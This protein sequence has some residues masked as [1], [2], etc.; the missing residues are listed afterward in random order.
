[1]EQLT[2]LE[3]LQVLGSN[4][5]QHPLF[6]V[7]LLIPIIIF[8]S[9]KK[10]GKK[11]F[12]IIYL[13]AI[14]FV[15]F[16]GNNII[17]ELFDNLMDGLFMTLYFPN[18]ITLFIVVVLCSIFALISLFSKKM[19]KINKV[20]NITGFAIV[21]VIFCLILT[22]VKVNQINIYA[23]NALYSNNELLTLMQLLIGTF[24]L[25]VIAI[26]II[27]GINRVTDIL[28]GKNRRKIKYI[29]IN[30][31]KVG[32]INVK[33]NEKPNKP[34]LKPFKFDVNKIESIVVNDSAA[35]ASANIF[36]MTAKPVKKKHKKVILDESKPIELNDRKNSKLKIINVDTN[37]VVRLNA[38][39]LGENKLDKK[40]SI[41]KVI[42]IDY[43]KMAQLNAPLLGEVK[44]DKRRP[45]L[46]KFDI[47]PN[48]DISLNV[49]ENKPSK[50][51]I[52]KLFEFD[53]KKANAIQIN[54]NKTEEN[55]FD[56][57]P[58]LMKPMENMVPKPDLMKPMDENIN[59]IEPIVYK[60]KSSKRKPK[61]S[62]D[63]LNILNI[64]ATLDSVSKCH[65]MKDVKLRLY[66]DN[67]KVAVDNLQMPNFKNTIVILRK[68][69]LYKH[70]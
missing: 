47:N 33:D 68:F 8:R 39:L 25:Q 1:M 3:K 7:L 37:K 38:P 57:K 59:K 26:L 55:I 21:Q 24:A 11:I 66:V 5:L 12:I 31:N 50:K 61:D 4:I 56:Q 29:K 46:K 62:V 44:L 54:G 49:P 13:T 30:N 63:N 10:N 16:I 19:Y 48:K 34:K 65:L 40:K 20:I 67:P 23:D 15:L 53:K 58:D 14:V 64:Q 51:P 69:R 35:P 52:L 43:N 17:F 41:I 9:N 36:D 42:E 32:Y 60:A 27:N 28:D 2:L 45:K 6:L 22:F 18:F 70:R